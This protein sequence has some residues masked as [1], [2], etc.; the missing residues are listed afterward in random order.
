MPWASCLLPATLRRGTEVVVTG[1]PRKRVG[2]QLPRGF[3]SHPL[4][5]IESRGRGERARAR[6][7][8][9]RLA[10]TGGASL[11]A[12]A[13]CRL[14]VLNGEVSE[15]LKEHAWR[16]CV[17]ETPPR[18]RIPASPPFRVLRDATEGRGARRVSARPSVRTGR[19][20][21]RCPRS[22]V[23]AGCSEGSICKA[24]RSGRSEAYSFRTP[25]RRA[26]APTPQMG[27]FQRPVTAGSGAGRHRPPHTGR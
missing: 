26:A 7:T 11:L 23:L 5:Q 18:V 17:G 24:A 10:I 4:R 20:L 13:S 12:R 8:G 19:S 25:Q 27:P 14:P 15:W 22:S 21:I 1:P 3:E 2:G 9:M 16:A 6:S